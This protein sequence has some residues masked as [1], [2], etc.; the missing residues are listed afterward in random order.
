MIMRIAVTALLTTALLPAA[1]DSATV[2][3]GPDRNRAT[4]YAS[5]D[6]G[7]KL[8]VRIP[9]VTDKNRPKCT[10]VI[11]RLQ[12]TSGPKRTVPT[13]EAATNRNCGNRTDDLPTFS[14]DGIARAWAKLCVSSR[15]RPASPCSETWVPLSE[16]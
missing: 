4:I 15:S 8:T 14:R 10:W 5:I 16:R 6:N 7:H 11:L 13:W 2:V 1:T 3:T 12:R 9:R